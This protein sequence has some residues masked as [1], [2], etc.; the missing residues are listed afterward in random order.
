M[1]DASKFTNWWYMYFDIL[2]WVA[3]SHANAEEWVLKAAT[4]AAL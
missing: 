2:Y 1:I 4:K 3:F